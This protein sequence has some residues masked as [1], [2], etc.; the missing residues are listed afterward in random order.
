M[1]LC[2]QDSLAEGFAYQ[3]PSMCGFK[4]SLSDSYIKEDFNKPS[5]AAAFVDPKIATWGAENT[6]TEASL[7]RK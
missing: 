6:A 7:L 1:S 2:L 4:G 3:I 5:G